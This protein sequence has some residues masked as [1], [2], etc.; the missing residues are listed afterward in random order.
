MALGA[1]ASCGLVGPDYTRPDI[2]I[3]GRFALAPAAEL[4]SAAEDQWWRALNDPAL[5]RLMARGMR[6]NLDIQAALVRIREAQAQMRA[7]GIESQ[8][9]G[10]L[11]LT[12]QARAVNSTFGDTS[13]A[14]LAPSFVVDLFGG[15]Q[16]R[17]EQAQAN[18]EAAVYDEG[19]ARLA[20]QQAIVQLYI[21]LRYYQCAIRLRERSINN[22]NRMVGIVRD[23]Q[24][25]N[26]ETLISV[27]R[28]QAELALERA[29]LPELQSS[30][31]TTAYSIATLLAEPGENVLKELAAFGRGQPMPRRNLSPGVPAELLR[32]RPDIRAAE[33]RLASATAGIGIAESELYP[34]L[35]IDGSVTL[36][37]AATTK[38]I[39]PSVAIPVFNQK[40]RMA[41]RDAAASRAKQ[42]EIEWR[43]TVLNG[44]EEVQSSLSRI[45]GYDKRL[46]RLGVAVREYRSATN[47][48]REAFRLN[49]L[50]LVELLDAEDDLTDATLQHALAKRRYA[51]SWAQLNT[52]IGQ[53]WSA[54]TPVIRAATE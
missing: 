36:T 19:A 11:D 39:G 10:A 50:T 41:Q 3:P 30:V 20:F 26:D 16:R 44:I 18:F 28:A 27:R 8:Y 22:R 43:Q 5:D 31:E 12:Y 54:G 40:T 53:G 21:D 52:A 37:A 35:R 4:Q 47:L 24:S 33:A 9:S 32:N 45:N 25:V 14:R 49:A 7:V 6:Q 17:R 13:Q 29:A 23:R 51:T 1:V 42:A 46:D 48:L 15:R 2:P 34:S 38:V